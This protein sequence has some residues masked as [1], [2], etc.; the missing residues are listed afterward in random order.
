MLCFSVHSLWFSCEGQDWGCGCGG[1][2]GKGFGSVVFRI[3]EGLV[4]CRQRLVGVFPHA[5]GEKVDVV[6]GVDERA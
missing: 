4:R 5:C 6:K 1:R 2:V 3:G